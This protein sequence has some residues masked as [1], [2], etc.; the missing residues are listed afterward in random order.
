MGEV[1]E[2]IEFVKIKALLYDFYMIFT[3]PDFLLDQVARYDNST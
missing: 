1:L 2:Y 3:W